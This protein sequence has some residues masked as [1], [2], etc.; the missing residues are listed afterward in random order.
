LTTTAISIDFPEKHSRLTTLFRVFLAIPLYIFGYVYEIL[1]LIC[2]LVTWF[3]MV[4]TAR[5]PSGLY[6][7]V[8]GYLRFYGRFSAY[9][10]L[11]VD[12]YPPF[13]GGEFADYPV[14]V[15]I[16]ER[17]AK[18]SRLKA[19]FRFI[20][21]I[22][23]YIVVAVLG[24]VLLVVE[25]LAWIIILISGRMPAFIADYIQFTLGWAVRL[26]GLYL[27]LVENYS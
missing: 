26:L 7:F 2:V 12:K 6:K 8:S 17:K 24:M 5:Y 22:P 27:L 1:A 9:L 21:V 19:F 25:I 18:Y 11:A 3:V 10:L 14:Q 16:P 15:T 20:Y 23:A 13:S 4:I